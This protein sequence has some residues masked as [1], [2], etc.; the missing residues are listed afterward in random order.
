MTTK[1]K[2]VKKQDAP[3]YLLPDFTGY[4][5][6][7]G[8]E[9]HL[10][11]REARR[12]YYDNY[13]E[14]DLINYVWTWMKQNDY[15]KEQIKLL[16]HNWVSPSVSINCKL[17]LDGVPDFNPLH[18]A[19]WNEL[20]GTVGDL[21]PISQ[22]LKLL[23]DDALANALPP[24][25]EPEQPAQKIT[26]QDRINEQA[27]L[28]A[29]QIDEWL[30]ASLDKD[31]DINSLNLQSLFISNK[32]TPVHVKRICSFYDNEFELMAKLV[33]CTAKE[34]KLLSEEEQAEIE[35][36]R[37]GYS[38]LSK[39]QLKNHYNALCRINEEANAFINTQKAVRKTRAVKPKQ[40]ETAI[41]NLKYLAN[42]TT[43]NLTSIKPETIIGA[44]ALW[45][46]NTKTRKLGC[47]YAKKI[48]PKGLGRPGSGLSIKGSAI[49]EFD[50]VK[51]V[52]KT[53]R[54]PADVLRAFNAT[55]TKDL[56]TFFDKIQ[57]VDSRMN[58]RINEHTVLLRIGTVPKS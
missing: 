10:R 35:Q 13:K 58:G 7:T 45:I 31:W 14:T 29:S 23:I 24:P 56:F 37:E 55:D 21:R 46:Y 2:K 26:V 32:L 49:D 34:F 3:K 28:I 12:F 6:W 17:I 44:D 50:V 27:Q 5:A 36:L 40:I 16:Q 38:N 25:E 15:S 41:A 42:D 33:K 1:T 11:L 51:S 22:S 8:E 54:K 39:A 18:A 48:D 4:E 52:Q 20:K 19:Y 57:T 9:Y 30:Y 53:V 43:N 47:Y